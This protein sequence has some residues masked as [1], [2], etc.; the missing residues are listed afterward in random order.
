MSVLRVVTN[1]TCC[2]L[3]IPAGGVMGA[4]WGMALGQVVASLVS[5]VATNVVIQRRIAA[6]RSGASD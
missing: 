6:L 2:V 4:A 1:A 3:F 5:I